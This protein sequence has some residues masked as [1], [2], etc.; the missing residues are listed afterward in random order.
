[1]DEEN[2][3]VVANILDRAIAQAG[4]AE[5][6]RLS[7]G[8]SPLELT[9]KVAYALG[10][11]RL[12][13]I[14]RMPNYDEWVA[15]FYGLWYQPGHI[16]LAYRMIDHMIKDRNAQSPV[17]TGNGVL[18]VVDFGCGSFAMQFGVALVAATALSQGQ[19][20]E[21]IKITAI[22]SSDA[23]IRMGQSIWTNFVQSVNEVNDKSHWFACLQQICDTIETD[24]PSSHDCDAVAKNLTFGSKDERWLSAIHAVYEEIETNVRNGLETLRNAMQ[25]QAGFITNFDH[26]RNN[27]LANRISPFDEQCY[28]AR[29]IS[30]ED[31]GFSD[32]AEVV[33][34][35]R[36]GI[37]QA[38]ESSRGLQ[39]YD[40][41]IQEIKITGRLQS[42]PLRA[43]NIRFYLTRG[44][45][46]WQ[47]RDVRYHIYTER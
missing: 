26:F 31:I 28:S 44:V 29:S 18:R 34:M 41:K 24:I 40:D 5:I 8:L 6:M 10:Q 17:L 20:I 19:R 27:G 7:Q 37:F 16:N 2:K 36:R 38:L 9:E 25:P 3:H 32:S 4:V 1:M 42:D 13:G 14:G 30:I 11:L 47:P 43:D 15:L 35:V 46:N 45:V 21:S 23:M 39:S 22:D 12:L 33:T